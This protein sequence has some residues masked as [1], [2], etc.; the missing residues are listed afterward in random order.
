MNVSEDINLSEEMESRFDDI[1]QINSFPKVSQSSILKKLTRKT[2][3]NNNN[4]TLNGTDLITKGYPFN[5]VESNTEN[6]LNSQFSSFHEHRETDSL[7]IF[8]RQVTSTSYVYNNKKMSSHRE[9]QN[10]FKTSGKTTVAP[11]SPYINYN[12]ILSQTESHGSASLRNNGTTQPFNF[13]SRR[14]ELAGTSVKELKP[15]F[16]LGRD[17][18]TYPLFEITPT[19]T[20]THN[21]TKKEKHSSMHTETISSGFRE[22]NIQEKIKM[23]TTWDNANIAD[24]TNS[25]HSASSTVTSEDKKEY[26]STEMKL[27][28]NSF[29]TK[30]RFQEDKRPRFDQLLYT[31]PLNQSK[32]T[33]DYIFNYSTVVS[34]EI[35]SE[36]PATFGNASKDAKIT[37]VHPIDIIN[38]Y[39]YKDYVTQMRTTANTTAYE[40]RTNITPTGTYETFSDEIEQK[41]QTIV[42]DTIEGLQAGDMHGVTDSRKPTEEDNKKTAYE[43]SNIIDSL[44]EN[45]TRRAATGS[46]KKQM[47]LAHD[48]ITVSLYTSPPYELK[49]K[50]VVIDNNMQVTKGRALVNVTTYT[51]SGQRTSETMPIFDKKEVEVKPEVDYVSNV[52]LGHAVN[53]TISDV[54]LIKALNSKGSAMSGSLLKTKSYKAN[55]TDDYNYKKYTTNNART[56]MSNNG[57]NKPEFLNNS[58]LTKYM[59]NLYDD[60]EEK[61]KT[62]TKVAH[63]ET[64]LRTSLANCSITTKYNTSNT[65]LSMTTAREVL[66]LQKSALLEEKVPNTRVSRSAEV[67]DESING[68]VVLINDV[69]KE[70]GLVNTTDDSVS[71]EDLTMFTK[72]PILTRNV[73]S[74]S[75]DPIG[76]PTD[77]NKKDGIN[78]LVTTTYK[79]V[80]QFNTTDRKLVNNAE[81]GLYPNLYLQSSFPSYKG[82]TIDLIFSKS[83]PNSSM[84]RNSYTLTTSTESFLGEI[85]S[86]D[87]ILDTANKTERNAINTTPKSQ[88]G[89]VGIKQSSGCPKEQ[90]IYLAP[91]T[92]NSVQLDALKNTSTSNKPAKRFATT[93]L[94]HLMSTKDSHTFSDVKVTSLK[95]S[96]TQ[97]SSLTHQNESLSGQEPSLENVSNVWLHENTLSYLPD[98]TKKGDVDLSKQHELTHNNQQR[99]KLG[100]VGNTAETKFTNPVGNTYHP[101]TTVTIPIENL[102]KEQPS[103]SETMPMEEFLGRIQPLMENVNSDETIVPHNEMLKTTYIL[104]KIYNPITAK[105]TDSNSTSLS[106]TPTPVTHQSFTR[107]KLLRFDSNKPM[108]EPKHRTTRTTV[109]NVSFDSTVDFIDNSSIRTSQTTHS[110]IHE[111]TDQPNSQSGQTSKQLGMDTA[112]N[113]LNHYPSTNVMKFDSGFSSETDQFKTANIGKTT[114]YLSIAKSEVDK[115]NVTSIKL[116]TKPNQTTHTAITTRPKSTSTVYYRLITIWSL[117][118]AEVSSS[119]KPFS[120]HTTNVSQYPSILLNRTNTHYPFASNKEAEVQQHNKSVSMENLSATTPGRE[121]GAEGRFSDNANHVVDRL[122]TKLMF[123]SNSGKHDTVSVSNVPEKPPSHLKKSSTQTEEPQIP[124]ILAETENVSLRNMNATTNVRNATNT[125]LPTDFITFTLG[126]DEDIYSSTDSIFTAAGKQTEK[127]ARIQP[128]QFHINFTESPTA[129]L[130]PSSKVDVYQGAI[131]MKDQVGYYGT[132]P[133]TVSYTKSSLTSLKENDSSSVDTISSQPVHSTIFDRVYTSHYSLFRLKEISSRVANGSNVAENTTPE[134][135]FFSQKIDVDEEKQTNNVTK[136]PN[137][138]LSFNENLSIQKE[139]VESNVNQ[140]AENLYPLLNN[141]NMRV[142]STVTSQ[143][144]SVKMTEINEKTSPSFI[145]SSSDKSLALFSDDHL[146]GGFTNKSHKAMEVFLTDRNES[147]ETEPTESNFSR[148]VENTSNIKIKP[149]NWNSFSTGQLTTKYIKVFHESTDPETQFPDYGEFTTSDHTRI[150]DEK[151][152]SEITGKDNVGISTNEI[153]S[154]GDLN[155]IS[156]APPTSTKHERLHETAISL[157]ISINERTR[158][159]SPQI[160]TTSSF[161]ENLADTGM[162]TADASNNSVPPNFAIS[163][164]QLNAVDGF[165]QPVSY[166]PSDRTINMSIETADKGSSLNL[167]KDTAT[168]NT[169]ISSSFPSIKTFEMT[170]TL[171][172]NS[173]INKPKSQSGLISNVPESLGIIDSGITSVTHMPKAYASTI[174]GNVETEMLVSED[175]ITDVGDRQSYETTAYDFTA[176]PVKFSDGEKSQKPSKVMDKDDNLRLNFTKPVTFDVTSAATNFMSRQNY[177]EPQ[178]SENHTIEQFPLTNSIDVLPTESSNIQMLYSTKISNPDN[179][180]NVNLSDTTVNHTS[181]SHN[182]DKTKLQKVSSSSTTDYFSENG[183]LGTASAKE[184]NLKE[185]YKTIFSPITFSAR[186]NEE[187]PIK[188]DTDLSTQIDWRSKAFY[189]HTRKIDINAVNPKLTNYELTENPYSA[190]ETFIYMNYKRMPNDV[191]ETSTVAQDNQYISSTVLVSPDDG[192]LTKFTDIS[193]PF[194]RKYTF[195]IFFILKS[196]NISRKKKNLTIRSHLKKE[197]QG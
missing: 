105:V 110:E 98:L 92:H 31:N 190:T 180:K 99:S 136:V 36:D 18:A 181:H 119:T 42:T 121:N 145:G 44:N 72:A 188:F 197:R 75:V 160:P 20:T 135:E 155:T 116:T 120:Q 57:T 172:P 40:Q 49:E 100:T 52:T 131:S 68:S 187:V 167:E 183:Y 90:S 141:T 176:V 6:S 108:A 124:K 8:D 177:L 123:S 23:S 192:K 164:T 146:Y 7:D 174:K 79:N 140:I 118:P 143:Y 148:I 70:T 175:V 97:E 115:Q 151:L 194:R 113:L 54:T 104:D 50:Q 163:A 89:A 95:R 122:S 87:Q 81:T 64:S 35:I 56:F 129:A 162:N 101:K 61:T 28:T 102:F 14:H 147:N 134:Q 112:R 117:R 1:T 109:N 171:D 158:D 169:R 43:I 9:T 71:N 65:S 76:T 127:P 83:Y 55:I 47:Y 91:T 132:K 32:T 53:R 111:N 19:A 154:K 96:T 38:T 73:K 193:S 86:F 161:F 196:T 74:K 46:T 39:T 63:M 130:D 157:E 144:E 149:R 173:Y 33:V 168:P 178:S 191:V 15:Q 17:D 166:S 156:K 41:P 94:K 189:S 30:S 88:P 170:N 2:D 138:T 159:E 67:N 25:L 179:D 26:L 185:M 66:M 107:T 11:T 85:T 137:T 21:V 13:E 126:K 16:T 139:A 3:K 182:N 48:N 133:S 10:F 82:D 62:N 51:T 78:V 106:T 60:V 45:T 34:R 4:S 12:F 195:N 84:S 58:G 80:T 59:N 153:L 77:N 114:Q 93:T 37:T 22:E 29:K 103:G 186:R 69:L 5:V 27:Y 184:H 142:I 24:T 150:R 152:Q 125:R 128:W 165:D